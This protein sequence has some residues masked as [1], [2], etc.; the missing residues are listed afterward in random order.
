M[1][2]D[3]WIE[4]L[5]EKLADYETP[6]PEGAWAEI[7]AALQQ[8]SMPQRSRF[9][10]L[11]R[12][13]VA[14]SVAALLM[15]GGYLWWSQRDK[16]LTVQ[17]NQMAAEQPT[18]T[19]AHS[20]PPHQ[21]EGPEVESATSPNHRQTTNS[22]PIENIQTPPPAPPLDGRGEAEEESATSAEPQSTDHFIAK[23]RDYQVTKLPVKKRR[24]SPTI[25][26][27]AI[28]GMGA[29]NSR[30]GV[31][32]AE[33]LAKQ[34][35]ETYE[36]SNFASARG[37]EP[38]YLTGYEEREH[39]HQ[40]FICG[41]SL[42]YPLTERLSLTTGVVYTKLSSDFTQVMRSQKIEQEQTL[43]YVGVPL[44]LSYRIWSYK[45]FRTYLSAG[46]KADWNVST[47][48]VTEGVTQELPKDRMQW[49]LNGNLGLQYDV[50]PQLGLY[51]EPGVSWY[52]D[53][54]SLLRNYFKDKPLNFNVQMGLRLTFTKKKL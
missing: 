40:P 37:Y 7:E 17:E 14:A 20:L 5:R 19:T 33:A 25:S 3:S 46:A 1:K 2:Q 12:W 34:Y 43:H 16:P 30:N 48:L 4:Q 28:N 38:I 26:L 36:H 54:G 29:Q 42:S 41:L 10:A 39:H 15:G 8:Q 6:A 27:Y 13:A 44:S 53:N 45:G 51:V 31:E 32:M 18:L 49:S 22:Q 47:H 9:V 35:W 52:P 24:K 50:V 11:R 23:E 21:E